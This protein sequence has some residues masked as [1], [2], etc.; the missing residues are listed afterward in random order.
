MICTR[1]VSK[2]HS[3][4]KNQHRKPLKEL[5]PAGFLMQALL[6]PAGLQWASAVGFPVWVFPFGFPDG[7]TAPAR[8]VS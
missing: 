6:V 5:A 1:L 8:L 7:F 3:A 2:R 4:G